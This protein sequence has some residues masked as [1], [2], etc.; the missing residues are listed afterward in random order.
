MYAL[1]TRAIRNVGDDLIHARA[2]KLIEHVADTPPLVVAKAWQPLGASLTAAQIAEL[3]AIIVPGGPGAR[4]GIDKV[5]PFF[6]EAAARG[7]PVHFIGV[8]SRFFPGTSAAGARAMDDAS[9]QRLRGFATSVPIGVRDYVTLDLLRA[10]GVPA[11]LNGCPAWYSLEHLGRRPTPP[12][13]IASVAFTT[14]G[15]L[16]FVPQALA[17]M[18]RTRELLPLARV[19]VGFHHGIAVPEATMAEANVRFVEQ[20]RALGFECVDLSEHH[21]KLTIY[22]GCDVHLGYRVHAHIYFLSLRKP[23]FL[24]AEDSRGTGVLHALGGVGRPAWS[25]LAEARLPVRRLS[26]WLRKPDLMLAS[27]KDL[28]DW[29][30]LALERERDLGFP[31]VHEAASAIDRAFETRM[32]PFLRRVF[33]LGVQTLEAHAVST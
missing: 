16:R 20:A 17:M 10:R 11:Q 25:A 18:R 4:R 5:Y 12:T 6:E 29:L 21:E 19:L 1:M 8:G 33:G 14:P 27:N 32:R 22:A 30:G 23:S 2:R 13:S 31:H 28:G 9:A 26:K 15:D 7:I 3:R 24:F